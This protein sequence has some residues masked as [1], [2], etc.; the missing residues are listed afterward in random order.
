MLLAGGGMGRN[1]IALET[2]CK[3]LAFSGYA[4]LVCILLGR[5]PLHVAAQGGH[6]D[7][8]KYLLWYK[9][10]LDIQDVLS[11]TPLHYCGWF[12]LRL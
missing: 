6:I 10:P 1:Q 2:L 8:I 9:S 12:F 7:C 3:Y 5:T 11:M 4:M